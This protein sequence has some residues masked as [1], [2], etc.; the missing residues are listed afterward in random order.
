MKKIIFKTIAV[1]VLMCTP[2]FMTSTFADT[3]PDPGGDPTGDPVGGG[4]SIGGGLII[5]AAL[6][7]GYGA[8]KVYDARKKLM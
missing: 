4:A 8:K 1:M 5:M 2:L 3:P 6:G 7:M